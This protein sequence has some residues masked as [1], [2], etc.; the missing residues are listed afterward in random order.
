MRKTHK[1]YFIF[2]YLFFIWPP[3]I[4]AFVNIYFPNSYDTS[5]IL[6]LYFNLLLIIILAGVSLL[7]IYSNHLH[8]PTR[9][10][11]DYLIF[12]FFGNVIMYFYTFQTLLNLDKYVT[13]YIS[14]LLVL[15]VFYFLISR[16][17]SPKELW[18]L[19]PIFIVYDY[20]FIGL[21]KCGWGYYYYCREVHTYDELLTILFWVV[22]LA[23]FTYYIYRI[24]LYRMMDFFKV[25]NL[26]LVVLV[27]YI[28]RHYMDINEKFAL[29]VL[30]LLPL[31]LII[32][33][34]IK[35]VTKTYKHT[36][37]LFYIRTSTLAIILGLLGISNFY[38]GNLD[39]ELLGVMV[40]I[41]YVSLGISILRYLLH[42]DVNES[43]PIDVLRGSITGPKYIKITE[44]I[45]QMIREQYNDDLADHISIDD[46]SFSLAAIQEGKV[47]GFIST[48]SHRLPAPFEEKDEAY[49][50]VLEVDIEHRNQGIASKL[51]QASETYFKQDNVK[52]IRAWSST[53]K[54]EAL[55]LWSKLGFSLVPAKVTSKA[56][57][58]LV[59]GFYAVKNIR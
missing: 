1:Y 17:I 32:D 42:I 40:F 25:A 51:I 52:Q 34:I 50:N 36:L 26:I 43:N 13:I 8:H 56:T 54:Y 6:S 55:H 9:Q 5:H 41:T 27:A 53:D 38:D 59:N 18:Y 57:N 22:L 15:A 16:K 3:F 48:Y 21:R 7:L 49:I 29:T 2:S 23:I 11:R 45:L 24:I 44:K 30:I 46:V 20:V 4:M 47:L 31:L 35:I 33:F 37:L 14:L 58:E 10:E 19:L 28:S 39:M 12:G